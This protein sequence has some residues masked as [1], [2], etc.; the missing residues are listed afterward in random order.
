MK[1]N[2]LLQ[3]RVKVAKA[4]L[5]VFFQYHV[6]AVSAKTKDGYFVLKNKNLCR[7]SLSRFPSLTSYDKYAIE[8]S[9]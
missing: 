4:V 7:K 3:A 1:I 9:F 5:L 8:L 2:S 6:S